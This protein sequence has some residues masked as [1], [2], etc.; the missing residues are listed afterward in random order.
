MAATRGE[1]KLK[2]EEA[3]SPP[4]APHQKK[5]RLP[6]QQAFPFMYD[7]KELVKSKNP[8]I[9]QIA[10]PTD[11][12]TVTIAT[13]DDIQIRKKDIQ[14]LK[15]IIV[16]SEKESECPAAIDE[17]NISVVR[18]EA[19]GCLRVTYENIINTVLDAKQQ[20]DRKRLKGS[21]ELIYQLPSNTLISV[22]TDNRLLADTVMKD[23]AQLL[24]EAKEANY[25]RR[26]VY[27]KDSPST[28]PPSS[29][30]HSVFR[31]KYG[32][33]EKGMGAYVGYPNPNAPIGTAIYNWIEWIVTLGG[34]L[35]TIKNGIKIFTEV[36]PDYFKKKTEAFVWDCWRKMDGI[37]TGIAYGFL[38]LLTIPV[39]SVFSLW[40]FIGKRITSP[41]RSMKDAYNR[42]FGTKERPDKGGVR[43]IVLAAGSL[44]LTTLAMGAAL[45][46]LAPVIATVALLAPVVAVLKVAVVA[47]SAKAGAASFAIAAIYSG[48]ALFKLGLK[49]FLNWLTKPTFV[50]GPSPSPSPKKQEQPP[51]SPS[52]TN[53]AQLYSAFSAAI[54]DPN[55]VV[56]VHS[57]ENTTPPST[58]PSTPERNNN[59]NVRQSPPTTPDQMTTVTLTHSPSPPT[60]HI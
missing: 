44:L 57:R 14:T 41:I 20:N 12:C 60:A 10:T 16:G 47:I 33:D 4:R 52:P 59:N 50:P 27:E 15:N 2:E 19:H 34:F 36:V 5:F 53:N 7:E 24:N 54:P 35:T 28:S 26:D 48:A 45:F 8:F 6:H 17:E 49:S 42:D 23:P 56:S 9:K 31:H 39:F 38:A 1:E 55:Q 30:P 18:I 58:L 43:G 25:D 11:L 51:H 40:H 29:P 3:S 21:L 13:S 22:G 32:A 37:G 46:F